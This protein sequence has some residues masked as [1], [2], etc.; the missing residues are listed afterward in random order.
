MRPSRIER[1]VRGFASDSMK[2][3]ADTM[4]RE[5]FRI[6]ILAEPVD[7]RENAKGNPSHSS[8]CHMKLHM[9]MERSDAGGALLCLSRFL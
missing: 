8:L 9:T 3:L 1:L 7:A 2:H 5:M 4:E 6:V